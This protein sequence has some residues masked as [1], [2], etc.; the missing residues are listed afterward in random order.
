MNSLIQWFTEIAQSNPIFGGLAGASIVGGILYKLKA[1]PSRIWGAIKWAC[2]ASVDVS[3]DTEIY[4]HL[5]RWLEQHSDRWHVRNFKA[6]SHYKNGTSVG[7]DE[8]GGDPEE[9]VLAPGEGSHWIWYKGRPYYVSRE[10]GDA[11]K[12]NM[13]GFGNQVRESISVVAPGFDRK[14]PHRLLADIHAFAN[15]D[16]ETINLYVMKPMQGWS[17]FDQKLPRPMDSIVLPPG[18]LEGLIADTRAFTSS[19]QWYLDRGV[20]Y[21]RGYLFAGPP[22]TGKSSLA[23]AVASH[24]RRNIYVLN[25]GS[26]RTDDDL[27]SAVTG[28]RGDAI[29]LIEDVDAA[30][31]SREESKDQA[32]LTL[33][34]LLNVLD[35][36][37][38]REGRILVMTSN[39]PERIDPALLRSGRVDYRLD[40]EMCGPDEAARLYARF[41]PERTDLIEAVRH[42]Y[43]NRLSPAAIQEICLSHRNDPVA[44]ERELVISLADREEQRA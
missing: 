41:F 9:W 32:G 3:N 36:A 33:S 24:F 2:S 6:S 44:A 40:F 7:I 25:L 30:F 14:R 22:G 38:A 26:M 16:K 42:G 37:L 23:V 29:L 18:D 39:Y 20:P 1:I 35:G 43:H 21:R 34:A 5:L 27:I 4:P 31:K 8:A 11:A 10:I 13:T 17:V 19:I 15:K 28:V 12:G